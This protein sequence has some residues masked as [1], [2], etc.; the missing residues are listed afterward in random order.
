M[1]DSPCIGVCSLKNNVCIG[2]SRTAEEIKNWL[3]LSDDE[4]LKVIHRIEK[5]FESDAT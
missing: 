2:C 5:L 4:K 3:E 1:V